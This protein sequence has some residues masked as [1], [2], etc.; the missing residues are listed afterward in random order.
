[1]QAVEKCSTAFLCLLPLP[2]VTKSVCYTVSFRFVTSLV[3]VIVTHRQTFRY[4]NSWHGYCRYILTRNK[5]EKAGELRIE[6]VTKKGLIHRVE[7]SN[8]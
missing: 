5:K 4:F 3:K 2:H 8:H 7:A 6:V 1:M